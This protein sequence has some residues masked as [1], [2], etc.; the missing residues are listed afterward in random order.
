VRGLQ[1]GC[2]D[3]KLSIELASGRNS[4]TIQGGIEEGA[5]LDDEEIQNV[6]RPRVA[7]GARPTKHD[8]MR[9]ADRENARHDPTEQ[10]GRQRQNGPNPSA[11]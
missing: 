6:V 9:R 8:P 2:E 11:S 1:I 10:I 7:A 4:S 5:N 3:Q